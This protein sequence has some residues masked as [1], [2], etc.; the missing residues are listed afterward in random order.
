MLQQIIIF[1]WI[2][3]L[4]HATIVFTPTAGFIVQLE[5]PTNP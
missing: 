4:S 1:S 2:K 3:Q 5:L